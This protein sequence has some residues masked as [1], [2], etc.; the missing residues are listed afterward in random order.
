MKFA[1]VQITSLHIDKATS[2]NA[3][4]VKIQQLHNILQ[5]TKALF[6]LDLLAA[7]DAA[8]KIIINETPLQ[9]LSGLE[10]MLLIY[11]INLPTICWCT[12]RVSA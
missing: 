4:C 11:A 7:L 1:N 12:T 5:S 6:L 10:L 9:C 8:D 2:L 3:Y